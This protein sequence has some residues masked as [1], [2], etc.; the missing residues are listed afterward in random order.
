MQ[1]DPLAM[2]IKCLHPESARAEVSGG[3]EPGCRGGV[4]AQL[5]PSLALCSA[6]SRSRY[7]CLDRTLHRK[8]AHPLYSFKFVIAISMHLSGAQCHF[9]CQLRLQQ[10]FS[11]ALLQ[12]CV[13]LH[14]NPIKGVRQF[15]CFAS[16]TVVK[17]W[18]LCV[19]KFFWHAIR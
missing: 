13:P 14:W 6:P 2:A 16:H 8:C 4:A 9:L 5:T 15:N 18:S 19:G 1:I 11:E 7:R 17:S 3:G 10:F 12:R